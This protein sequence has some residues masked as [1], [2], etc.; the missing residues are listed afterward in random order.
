MLAKLLSLVLHPP[1]TKSPES[2]PLRCSESL[3]GWQRGWRWKSR[4]QSVRKLSD[5]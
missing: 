4:L 1:A 3:Y 2:Q 5:I